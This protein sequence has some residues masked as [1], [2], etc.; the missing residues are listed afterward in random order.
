MSCDAESPNLPLLTERLDRA[1]YARPT[2][3]VARDLIGCI[4]VRFLNG[5]DVSGRIV[6]TE[7]YGDESDLASH[8]A[9]YRRSRIEIMRSVPGTVYVYRIYGV[10]Y[11]FNIVAHEPGSSGAVLVRA[12]EPLSGIEA[13]AERRG[14]STEGAIANGPG[15]LA[16]AFALS[17]DDNGVDVVADGDIFV[18]RPAGA[19]EVAESVR[20]GISRDADRLWR[21]LD[22]TSR[23]VSKGPRSIPGPTGA[24]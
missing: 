18:T 2:V 6:E 16:Q 9:L 8:A 20:I 22:P 21:F 7:A 1:F 12:A 15:R 11:C 24:C 19:S 4:L 5:E 10:H 17:L 13:M 14:V 23:H 3:D